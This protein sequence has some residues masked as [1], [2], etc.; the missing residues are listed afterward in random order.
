MTLCDLHQATV[1]LRGLLSAAKQGLLVGTWGQGG[2]SSFSCAAFS[3]TGAG[4]E[5]ARSPVGLGSCHLKEV[6]ELA[7]A[8][9]SGLFS[10][11]YVIRLCSVCVEMSLV[12]EQTGWGSVGHR[13]KLFLSDTLSLVVG[14]CSP[15][16]AESFPCT[17]ALSSCPQTHCSRVRH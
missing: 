3:V 15:I 10:V 2:E 13:Q 7:R 1:T 6:A 17:P 14:V 5:G 16:P 4:T 12:W 9:S 11:H 8:S